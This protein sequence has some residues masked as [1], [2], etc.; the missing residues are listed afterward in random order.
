[1][2]FRHDTAGALIHTTGKLPTV[3][4]ILH[5]YFLY[6]GTNIQRGNVAIPNKNKN[7]VTF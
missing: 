2:Y 1:M 6:C 4:Q 3:W 7:S 5:K